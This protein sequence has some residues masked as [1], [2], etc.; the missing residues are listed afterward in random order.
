MLLNI[1]FFHLIQ[2]FWDLMHLIILHEF[3]AL[4]ASP[5]L[6]HYHVRFVS[7]FYFYTHSV[8]IISLLLMLYGALFYLFRRGCDPEDKDFPFGVLLHKSEWQ[9]RWTSIKL[10]QMSP[11]QAH[12]HIKAH[13]GTRTNMPSAHEPSVILV[14]LISC[15]LFSSRLPI[16]LQ[17]V[18]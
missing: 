3:Y 7:F 11:T 13:S 18:N 15:S 12:A 9:Q 5:N 6:R 4:N 2:P 10:N 8:I 16:W 1:T 17:V 14:S